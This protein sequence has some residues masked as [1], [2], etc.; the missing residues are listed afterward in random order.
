M[1]NKVKYSAKKTHFRQDEIVHANEINILDLANKR[2]YKVQDSKGNYAEI[3]GCGGLSIDKRKN[4]WYC[5]SAEKGGGPI[6]LLMYLE[7]VSYE[8]SVNILLTDYTS[9]DRHTAKKVDFE[10][11]EQ[12]EFILPD[13]NNTYKH[14]YAYLSQTRRIDKEVIQYFVDQKLLYENKFRSCV[15]VGRDK[16]GNAKYASV[17]STNTNGA[18]FKGD[19]EASDKRFGF[20]RIGTNNVLTITEAPIDL[21]SYMTIF[22]KHNCN[23]LIANDHLLALGGLST[24][25]IRQYLDEHPEINEIKLGLDNDEH[26]IKKCVRIYCEFSD[27][28]SINRLNFRAKDI[29]LILTDSKNMESCIEDERLIIMNRQNEITKSSLVPLNSIYYLIN[30]NEFE[31]P[32]I[33]GVIREFGLSAFLEYISA[34]KLNDNTYS[35]IRSLKDI[36]NYEDKNL[37]K[38]KELTGIPNNIVQ[39]IPPQNRKL[40]YL[41]E[42]HQDVGLN[43][44]QLLKAKC[45]YNTAAI[46][47]SS[48]RNYTNEKIL[49]VM[50]NLYNDNNILDINE[51]A[52]EAVN[53]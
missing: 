3:K 4:R 40:K 24:F 23:E 27:H 34:D 52:Y 18:I 43:E 41:I 33:A 30:A 13:K 29:N 17:R 8:E 35:A 6:Q 42:N 9:Y 49:T 14:V 53:N 32:L 21:L 19:V 22:A 26:G 39:K 2:M 36:L 44:V 47:E 10:E 20:K 37:E 50:R 28:Y 38:L 11:S 7:G 16:E 1:E 31:K 46:Y 45:L 12:K 15:F 48:K 5:H 51:E 25:S